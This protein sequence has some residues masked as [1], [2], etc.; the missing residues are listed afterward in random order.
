MLA[1]HT[2]EIGF[3]VSHI[4]EQGF[5]RVQAIGGFDVHV[6][7]AQR[8]MVWDRAG[9]AASRRIHDLDQAGALCWMAPKPPNSRPRISSS[10]S[11]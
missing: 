1:A 11:A 8:V 9:N 10:T 7:P 4:D 5:L 3:L 2:D 6:L